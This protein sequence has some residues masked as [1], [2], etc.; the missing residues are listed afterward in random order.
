MMFSNSVLMVLEPV[1]VWEIMLPIFLKILLIDCKN[2]EKG[3]I[4]NKI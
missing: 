2:I 3:I 1:M 4:E